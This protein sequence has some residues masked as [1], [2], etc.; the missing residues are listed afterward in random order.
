MKKTLKTLIITLISLIAVSSVFVIV[1]AEVNNIS[2]FDQAKYYFELKFNSERDK[3]LNENSEKNFDQILSEIK[4]A[5]KENLGEDTLGYLHIALAEKMTDV[6]KNEI[7]DAILDTELSAESR[8][9][10]IISAQ[11]KE[12]ALNYERLNEAIDNEK[13]KDIRSMLIDVVADA[14]PHNIANIEKIVNNRSEGFYKAINSLYE[15]KPSE[16]IAI[17]DEILANYSG[18]YDEVFRGAFSIKSFQAILEPTDKNCEEYIEL[19]NRILATDCEDSKERETYIVS[20]MQETYNKKMLLWF[21]DNNLVHKMVGPHISLTFE[22]IFE[23]PA[24]VENVELFIYFYPQTFTQ[25]VWEIVNKH[26]KE[27]E[28][29]FNEHPELR[30]ELE[31]ISADNYRVVSILNNSAEER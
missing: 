26:I 29:F 9:T 23:E 5:E 22:K 21:K 14:T 3:I 17:A 31:K 8:T 28:D 24:T 30:E 6:D 10:I 13:Y 12:V 25:N 16:A 4:K 18:E 2:S 1:F 11:I 19:C 7:T 15:I 27:N 20:W